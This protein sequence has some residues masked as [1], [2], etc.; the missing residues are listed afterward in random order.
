MGFMKE[1]PREDRVAFFKKAKNASNADQRALVEQVKTK[2][3]KRERVFSHGG[4]FKPLSVWRRL[5]YDEDVIST[6]SLPQDVR[7]NRR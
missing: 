4:T 3:S 7:P 6:E 5:G 2:F 1:V